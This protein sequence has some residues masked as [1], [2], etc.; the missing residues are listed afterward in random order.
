MFDQDS[1]N[2][3]HLSQLVLTLNVT[4]VCQKKTNM[5]M[6]PYFSVWEVNTTKEA[7]SLWIL[8]RVA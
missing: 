2:L 8:K 1:T 7:K 4:Y 6:Q 3:D 5:G